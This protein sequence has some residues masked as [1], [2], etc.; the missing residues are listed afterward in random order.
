MASRIGILDRG[1]LVQVGTP[2]E[3]YERPVNAYV[4]A[5]LGSPPINLLPID[6]LPAIDAPHAATTVGA[7]TEHI[8]LTP[9]EAGLAEVVMVEHLGSEN[10][11]HVRAHGQRLVTLAPANREWRPGHR[12]QLALRRPLYFDASGRTLA[13]VHQEAR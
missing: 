6:A 3:I 8:E 9:S 1:T 5:R 2:Q 11:L 7:R 10:F 4:A 12:A 13:P